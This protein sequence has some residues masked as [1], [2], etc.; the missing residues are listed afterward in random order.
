MS[1]WGLSFR[2]SWFGTLL[3]KFFYLAVFGVCLSSCF[4]ETVTPITT[5]NTDSLSPRLDYAVK[6]A[7]EEGKACSISIRI[8]RWPRDI[9]RAF[10]FPVYYAD[11]P[12]MPLIGVAPES[13]QAYDAIGKRLPLIGAAPDAEATDNLWLF[14]ESTVRIE[15]TVQHA[16]SDQRGCAL[17]IP[18]SPNQVS[19]FDGGYFFAL[20][21]LSSDPALRWR[22]PVSIGL[23]LD[24]GGPRGFVGHARHSAL[25]NNYELMFVRGAFNPLREIVFSHRG[26]KVSLYETT[27]ENGLELMEPLVAQCLG[28][29][30][31]SLLPLPEGPYYVGTNSVFTGI[32]GTQGYWIQ[33]EIRLNAEVHLHEFI[34]TFVG[35]LTGDRG[36]PWFKEGLTS[37]LALLLGAQTGLISDTEFAARMLMDLSEVPAVQSVPLRSER[38]REGL[39]LP[40]DSGFKFQPDSFG[41]LGLVYNKGAQ[42]SM[43]LDRHIFENSGG[44]HSVFDLVRLL[45]RRHGSLFHRHEFIQAVSNLATVPSEGFLE[46]LF[47]LPGAFSRDSLSQTFTNLRKHGRF[48]PGLSAADSLSPLAKRPEPFPPHETRGGVSLER[49]RHFHS[50]F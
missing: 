25:H 44:V 37:Y 27:S 36:E 47:G 17:P 50:K 49:H 12:R 39:F 16:R 23:I 2:S 48:A 32:E 11:N 19:L 22:L 4:R 28:I 9:P 40:L 34:H 3:F 35:V 15:Y 6:E 1:L 8:L 33:S 14:P 26:R 24:G 13:V 21:Y 42:A 30:E 38:I 31:D 7:A 46:S 41:M 10:L 5:D 45:H 20:P 29:V 43:I 18:D